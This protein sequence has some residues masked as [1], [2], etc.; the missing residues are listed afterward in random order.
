VTISYEILR[1][2]RN[3]KYIHWISNQGLVIKPTDLNVH[4][5]NDAYLTTYERCFLKL[6]PNLRGSSQYSIELPLPA[7]LY[8]LRKA[9]RY[10]NE[11]YSSDC[12]LRDSYELPNI[13]VL[14]DWI[15]VLQ[16]SL[17][18]L[19]TPD[20]QQNLLI[21]AY[22]LQMIQAFF[23]ENDNDNQLSQNIIDQ[24]NTL[25]NN[26]PLASP[27]LTIIINT[28]YGIL[29]ESKSLAE[30]EQSYTIALLIIHKLYGD[31][32][33]RG[34]LSVPW[35]LFISWRLSILSR[36]QGRIH[37]AEYSEELFD[38]S[39]LSLAE[40]QV[41]AHCKTH[42]IYNEPFK[43][44]QPSYN[45]ANPNQKVDLSYLSAKKSL[46]NPTK[47]HPFTHWVNHLAYDENSVKIDTLNATLPKSSQM[48]KWMISYMP[49]FQPT[50]ILWDTSAL[51]DFFL[52]IMQ[53]SFTNTTSVSSVSNYSMRVDKSFIGLD[54]SQSQGI[55]SSISGQRSDKKERKFNPGGNLVQIFEKDPSTFNKKEISGTIYAWGQNDK[56]Q[57]GT[58]IGNA[59]DL[60][61]SF[62]KKTRIYYPKRVVLLK[63]TIIVSISC[64]HS[65]SIAITLDGQL[66]S[67]G[68]NSFSQLG[69]GPNTPNE[70]STPTII[71]GIKDVISVY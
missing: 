24:I 54:A 7:S 16:S 64:G 66:L 57:T 67:W 45:S 36:L 41:N 70:I 60:T 30:C 56:G 47:N 29:S 39:L 50:G 43:A 55:R 17:N 51:R 4:Y 63:D 65:H 3:D 46:K 12:F 61:G 21:E 53:S 18:C 13:E 14:N 26:S 48:L 32:R 6:I 31:P 22:F 52:S 58:F 40:N 25:V 71:T 5:T 19:Y 15:V 8:K 33:G 20:S 35:E 27:E 62:K 49:I 11:T 37:D 2:V 10:D 9:K 38:A 44:F 34:T 59:E 69:L 42:Y 1:Q 68:D 28:W 23:G